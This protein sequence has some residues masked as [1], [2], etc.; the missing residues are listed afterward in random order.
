MQY[1]QLFIKLIPLIIQLMALAEK[2]ITGPKSGAEKK[3]LVID[4]IKSTFDGVQGVSTGGQAETLTAVA[5][6]VDKTIDVA[7]AMLF[8]SKSDN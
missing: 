3:A 5:P 8:P 7:A 6:L 2:Y 1:F 4:A